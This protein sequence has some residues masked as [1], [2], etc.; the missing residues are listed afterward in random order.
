MARID[1]S[2]RRA[3]T[4]T[5]TSTGANLPTSAAARRA[6]SAERRVLADLANALFN[7]V[8]RVS[9]LTRGRYTYLNVV[10]GSAVANYVRRYFRERRR[11]LTDRQVLDVCIALH[12]AGVFVV[13][14]EARGQRPRAFA[15]TCAC[16]CHLRRIAA[17]CTPD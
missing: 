16:L 3:A 12:A 2:R 10:R 5:T 1:R 6:A 15:D 8:P 17:P 7:D 9:T 13:V 11:I 14:D 4:V